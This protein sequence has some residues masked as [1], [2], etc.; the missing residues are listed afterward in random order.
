MSQATQER[1]KPFR[2][3]DAA[4][5]EAAR[6]GGR[7][8]RDRTALAH[9]L[10]VATDDPVWQECLRLAEAFRRAQVRRLSETVGNGV[11]GPGPAALVASAAL[12]LA[13]SR[14]AYACG[15]FLLGARMATEARQQLAGA[16][17]LC[18]D[19][20]RHDR[21]PSRTIERILAAAG[22]GRP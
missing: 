11:C 18:E 5:I 14:Y 6:A 9:T 20:R 13:A 19:E 8:L 1:G 17:E 22:R 12:A 21:R 7:A 2:A 4:T 16:H 10:A 15:D 3:G